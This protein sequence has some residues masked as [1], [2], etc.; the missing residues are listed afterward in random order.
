MCGIA[1]FLSPIDDPARATRVLA[2]MTDAIVHRGPDDAGHWVDPAAGVA[3]GHRRLSIVELS[4]LGHQPMASA[5]GRFSIV[6]NGEVYNFR[7][8]RAELEEKGHAFRGHSDTEVM[9]AAFEQ[10][11]VAGA[12]TRFVGMFA[13][14]LWDGTARRLFLARDRMGE[15]PLHYGWCGNAFLFGSE[16]KALR[17]H[18]AFD[19]V[20][21]RGALAA[22]LRHNYVPAPHT[23]YEGI[24]KLPPGTLL[25][26]DPARPGAEAPEPYWSARRVAEDGFTH[27]FP[28]TDAEAVDTLDRL[29]H[30][31]IRDQ[32][33]AD[34]PL[35]VF[36][37]GGIDS[38]TVAAVMQ[39]ISARPVRTFTIGF[40]EKGYDEAPHARAVAR[41]LGTEH[42]E[43]YV[44]P[45]EALDVIPRLPALYD[46]PFADVSQIPTFLVAHMARKH[47]TV[48][49]SGD[50]GD[51]LFWGYT[52]YKIALDT[53]NRMRRIPAP[54]RN[55]L[56]AAVRCLPPE[57]W[58]RLFAWAGPILARYGRASV[59]DKLHAAGGMLAAGRL[60][61]IYRRLVSHWPDPAAALLSG[62]EHGTILTD[63][64]N[65]PAGAAPEQ[66]MPYW[67]LFT[68]LPD[69]ILVKVDRAG[70]GVSLETREPLLD[71]RVVAFALGLPQHMKVRNGQAK[72]ALRQVLYRHVPRE[73]VER[74]KMG[75]GVPI[76]QWLKGPLRGWAEELLDERRLREQGYFKP[77]IIR[78]RWAQ[79][80]A[81]SRDWQYHLWDV[82]MFQAWLEGR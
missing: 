5:S 76:G 60:D 8:L 70:M 63:P 69:D 42:T 73:L 78:E 61:A 21:D 9:L 55:A 36:L 1:G 37:S 34:V 49:L 54:V 72:W 16:L 25:C 68:Y 17:A 4:P 75:F 35:G 56:A 59:G 57:R 27:P 45:Q 64:D 39:H 53:W 24:A 7:A 46:E 66:L 10:W 62:A 50:G 43:L 18:P 13:F 48:A 19:R 67:D 15:K 33:L 82:L 79:H 80:L 77:D 2:A 30:D 14:A 38:S 3:L 71:H 22:L 12:L 44:T 11:G 31:V 23:I 41:H 26:V 74:P 47:V 52:R 20:V 28:G 65:R 58:N 29:L 40:G 6:F 81:G 32:M 51:E